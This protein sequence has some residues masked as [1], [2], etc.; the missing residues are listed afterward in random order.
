[1]KVNPRTLKVTEVMRRPGQPGFN[2]G[3][4]AVEVGGS[5]WVG[6]FAGDRIAVLR[7]KN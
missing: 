2:G 4:V 6:S 1:V 7:A 5:Y 3:T